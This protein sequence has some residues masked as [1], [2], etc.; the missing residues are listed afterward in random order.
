MDWID[1]INHGEDWSQACARGIEVFGLPGD[2][3]ITHAR[4]DH[5]T[6]HFRDHSDLVLFVLGWP[7]RN[8]STNLGT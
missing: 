6:W 5:M 7:A 1:M 3:Y 8:T 4:T 2:R